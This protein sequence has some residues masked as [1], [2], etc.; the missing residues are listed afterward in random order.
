T[1]KSQKASP[2]C[3]IADATFNTQQIM[4]N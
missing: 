4:K 1:M 3:D 2:V